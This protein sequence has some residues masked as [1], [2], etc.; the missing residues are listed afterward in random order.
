MPI[1]EKVKILKSEFISNFKKFFPI[2]EFILTY[3]LKYAKCPYCELEPI[4]KMHFLI[5]TKNST[6]VLRCNQQK[7]HKFS[8]DYKKKYKNMK[9]IR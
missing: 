4:G 1:F 7:K 3:E 6:Y 9:I 2:S 5:D 8:Y